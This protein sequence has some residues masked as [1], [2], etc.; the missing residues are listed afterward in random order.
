ML[1]H[2]SDKELEL[3]GPADMGGLELHLELSPLFLKVIKL[4]VEFFNLSVVTS[5][6]DA[7]ITIIDLFKLTHLDGDLIL[8][9][10]NFHLELLGLD[11]N[12]VGSIGLLLNLLVKSAGHVLELVLKHGNSLLALGL[13]LSEEL[14]SV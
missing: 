14:V 3:A 9:P 2:I 11:F 7:L 10:Y 4:S 5:F 6:L 12:L 13:L 1:V 8:L